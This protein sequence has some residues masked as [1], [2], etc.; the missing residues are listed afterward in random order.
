MTL[1]FRFLIQLSVPLLFLLSI[2]PVQAQGPACTLAL[3][4]A[5]RLLE[6]AAGS[7][8]MEQANR[9]LTVAQEYINQCLP[10]DS[11]G[12]ARNVLL[13]FDPAE[14]HPLEMWSGQYLGDVS[15]TDSGWELLGAG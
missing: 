4:E 7:T 14:G 13:S 3:R 5:N 11:D 12:L 9:V 6:S 2:L 10:F 1:R 8:D 15:L